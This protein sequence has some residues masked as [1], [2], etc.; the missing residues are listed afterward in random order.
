MDTK[1]VGG[2]ELMGKTG[3]MLLFSFMLG[4]ICI[5]TTFGV[6]TAIN[7]IF[8][9]VW[10]SLV[11]AL[12]LT[13][14]IFIASRVSLSALEWVLVAIGWIGTLLSTWAVRGLKRRGYS[15]FT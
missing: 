2:G 7:M 8:R 13:V 1:T 12:A 3:G 6:G 11:V 5:V 9:R 14:W 10:V 15:L 4:L